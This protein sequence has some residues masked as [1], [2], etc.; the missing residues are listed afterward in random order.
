M[1]YKTD[2]LQKELSYI[3]NKKIEEFTVKAIEELPDYFFEIPASSTGKYHPNYALGQGGLLRHVKACVVI[4][5]ELF[6]LEMFDYFTRD[7]KDIIISSLLLHDGLKHGI[8]KSEFSKFEHP[9]IIKDFLSNNDNLKNILPQEIFE[10]ITNNVAH[11]M[12]QW[13]D[14]PHSDIILEKPNN[15]MENFVHLVDYLASRKCIEINFD[16]PIS[17]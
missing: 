17:L 1:S 7:E 12:G 6:R 16:V 10:K 15:K 14:N 11:H 5:K 2:L 13:I 3:R 4:C 8:I 9:L